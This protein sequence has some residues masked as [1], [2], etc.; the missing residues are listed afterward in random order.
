[1]APLDARHSRSQA[2]PVAPWATRPTVSRADA[3]ATVSASRKL[4]SLRL[5]R[6][7]LARL[8][9]RRN[10]VMLRCPAARALPPPE[11]GPV[12]RGRDGPR[13]PGGRRAWRGRVG[14]RSPPWGHA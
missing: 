2:W 4:A 8:A 5:D 14:R 11:A 3:A 12:V 13:R 7:A 1:S 9:A 6:L 10:E